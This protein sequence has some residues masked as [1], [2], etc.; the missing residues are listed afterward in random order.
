MINSKAR[1]VKVEDEHK[2]VPE[3]QEVLKEWWRHLKTTTQTWRGFRWLGP[4][5]PEHPNKQSNGT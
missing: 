5:L 4:E 2:T 3:R 1:V